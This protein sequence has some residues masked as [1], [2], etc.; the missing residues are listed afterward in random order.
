MWYCKNIRGSQP[1]KIS[2]Q[3]ILWEQQL[4]IFWWNIDKIS[5]TA[6]SDLWGASGDLLEPHGKMLTL[7]GSFSDLFLVKWLVQVTTWLCWLQDR[8]WCDLQWLRNMAFS[9]I[10][11]SCLGP[12]LQHAFISKCLVISDFKVINIAGTW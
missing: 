4:A 10:W 7:L 5:G 8:K 2:K 6:H 11:P 3:I 9:N 1:E 12:M